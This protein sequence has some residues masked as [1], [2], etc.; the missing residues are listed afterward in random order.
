MRRSSDAG[1]SLVALLV[2]LALLGGLA[3]TALVSQ[4]NGSKNQG[5]QTSA[6]TAVNASPSNAATDIR[7]AAAVTCR[8]DYEAVDTAVSEYAAVNG[9]WPTDMKQ[10]AAMTREPITST[11]FEITINP[12]KPGQ[13]EVAAGGHPA[14]PGDDNCAYAG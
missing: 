12:A 7:A 3:T 10:V 14:L 1:R 6:T 9:K 2:A 4:P 11:R 8:A 13:V 5:H